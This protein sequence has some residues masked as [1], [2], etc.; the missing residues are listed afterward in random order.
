MAALFVVAL[1]TYAPE[2]SHIEI[3][4]HFTTNNNDNWQQSLTVPFIKNN[5]DELFVF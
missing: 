1:N 3:P 5:V 2:S 4:Q